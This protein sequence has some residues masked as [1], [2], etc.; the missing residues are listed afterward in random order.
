[1]QLKIFLIQAAF[2]RSKYKI[3]S[4]VKIVIS[5]AAVIGGTFSTVKIAYLMSILYNL[6]LL[7]RNL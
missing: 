2:N 6:P 1:S 7:E 3:K 5:T 4:T